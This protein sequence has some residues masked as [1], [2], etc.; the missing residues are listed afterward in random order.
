[1]E[2]R[3]LEYFAVI[4]EHRHLGRAAEALGLS[5]PALSKS[6]R[7]LE[8]SV[9]AKL[10]A[11]T[12]K[13]VELTPVGTALLGR[14]RGLRLAL[15]DAER[16]AADLGTGEAGDLRI[17]A[18]P[19]FGE[20]LLPAATAALFRETRNVTLSVS[21]G[22]SSSGLLPVLRKGELDLV[23]G[24]LG[25][26]PRSGL[27]REVLY[28]DNYVVYASAR[29]RLAGRKRVTLEDLAHERWA[30]ANRY[31]PLSQRLRQAFEERRLPVPAVELVSNSVLLRLR[32]VAASELLNLGSKRFLQQSAPRSHYAILPV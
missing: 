18:S 25:P 27:A 3:D 12:P 29:H 11:R 30:M 20:F 31:T 28:E 26:S 10:V 5:S 17:G 1:M 32:S 24:P 23:F 16:E 8:K 22:D 21:F 9:R 6:L 4:A 7:R 19:G 2:L 15:E 13:G 14:A